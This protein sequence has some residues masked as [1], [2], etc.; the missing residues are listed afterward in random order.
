M[1]C[2]LQNEFKIVCVCQFKFEEE[3]C[4]NGINLLIIHNANFSTKVIVYWIGF[5]SCSKIQGRFHGY[6]HFL[7]GFYDF[8]S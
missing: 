8:R 3:F 7:G 2:I 6:S 4:I 1:E 5:I